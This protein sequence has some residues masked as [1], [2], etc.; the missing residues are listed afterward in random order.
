MNNET[1]QR[2]YSSG[3]VKMIQKSSQKQTFS[4]PF[5]LA[6]AEY[7]NTIEDDRQSKDLRKTSVSQHD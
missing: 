6:R 2:L 7:A 3:L 4:L 1:A 5:C